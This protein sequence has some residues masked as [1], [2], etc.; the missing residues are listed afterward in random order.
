MVVV[1]DPTPERQDESPSTA[2]FVE[3][4]F[5]EESGG[6][7][8]TGFAGHRCEDY[9]DAELH[10]ISWQ[11]RYPRPRFTVVDMTMREVA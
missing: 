10:W 6:R 5:L 7:L 2:I 3:I 1:A 11:R 8:H 9:V 4:R